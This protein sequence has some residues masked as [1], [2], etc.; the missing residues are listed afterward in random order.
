MRGRR[1]P[2]ACPYLRPA[3]LT[4]RLEGCEV[5]RRAA[6]CQQGEGDGD[7]RAT[8]CVDQLV[9]V[10]VNVDERRQ[11]AQRLDKGQFPPQ[12]GSARRPRDGVEHAVM[13]G[14]YLLEQTFYLP[15]TAMHDEAKAPLRVLERMREQVQNVE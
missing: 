3:H 13:S 7:R 5:N 14:Q 8:P 2:S 1:S 11:R 4:R 10:E 6:P 9:V 15:V 12:N